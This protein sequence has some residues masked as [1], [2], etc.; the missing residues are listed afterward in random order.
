MRRTKEEIGELRT[1]M[2]SVRKQVNAYFSEARPEAVD[3]DIA[4]TSNLEPTDPKALQKCE[5]RR[6]RN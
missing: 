2:V 1:R 6:S 5:G 4:W 3:D